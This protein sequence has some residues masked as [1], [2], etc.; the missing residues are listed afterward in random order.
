MPLPGRRP[1]D[2]AFLARR[3]LAIRWPQE[4]P[5]AEGSRIWLVETCRAELD[6]SLADW[7]RLGG[8][9]GRPSAWGPDPWEEAR[10]PHENL[11]A[12]LLNTHGHLIAGETRIRELWRCLPG[13]RRAARA[14]SQSADYRQDWTEAAAANQGDLRRLL[15]ERRRALRIFRDLAAQYTDARRALHAPAS[16]GHS[17][18]TESKGMTAMRKAL[19]VAAAALS[20]LGTQACSSRDDDIDP[21]TLPPGGVTEDDRP[22]AKRPQP[23]RVGIGSDPDN[24]NGAP[25]PSRG[26]GTSLSR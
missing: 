7:R 14:V 17:P 10:L 16:I 1:A 15:V 4:R 23:V 5:P 25:G 2:P 11:A 21:T 8:D 6:W 18:S 24:P 26:L 3:L 20:L 22:R 12:R 19:I 9:P 13:Q